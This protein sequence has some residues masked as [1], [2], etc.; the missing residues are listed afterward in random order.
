MELSFSSITLP[1]LPSIS[2]IIESIPTISSL[3]SPTT[4]LADS[5]ITTSISS[6]LSSTNVLPS[7]REYTSLPFL[8]A[9]IWFCSWLF[10]KIMNLIVLYIPSKILKLLSTDFE[11]TL[12]LSTILLSL[13]LILGV[14]FLIVRYKYLSGYSEDIKG[15][16]N[17]LKNVSSGGPKLKN[18]KSNI[19]LFDNQKKKFKKSTSNYLDEFLSAIKVFGYLEKSVFHE[20]TKNMTTQKLSH[21]EILYLDEKLG[22]SIVVEGVIQVY[23]RI[24]NE[25]SLPIDADD[26]DGDVNYEKGDMLILGNQRY[27][28]LNEV[29]SGSPLSS[30]ISTLDL[31]KPIYYEDELSSNLTNYNI[32]TDSFSTSKNMH[33]NPLDP[34][35]SPFD[36]IMNDSTTAADSSPRV[37]HIHNGSEYPEI[38]ARPKPIQHQHHHTKQGRHHHRRH[39]HEPQGA[40]IA[41]IPY[42][43]FQR[44]QSKYPKATSHMVTMV[45][46]RLYKV[47]MNTIHNYLGLTKEIIESEIRLNDIKSTPTANLPRYLYD[48]LLDKMYNKGNV[49]SSNNTSNDT[50]NDHELDIPE[51]ISEHL[52]HPAIPHKSHFS[53]G[54]SSRYVVLDSR[55]KSTHPGDLLS[56]VPLSR[57]SEYYQTHSGENPPPPTLTPSESRKNVRVASTSAVT[58]ASLTPDTSTIKGSTSSKLK[59]EGF[60]DDYSEETEEKSLR[61]AIIENMFK[62]LGISEQSTLLFSKINDLNSGQTSRSS[63]I[64]GLSNLMHHHNGSSQGSSYGGNVGNTPSS[65]YYDPLTGRFRFDTLSNYSSSPISGNST[66]IKVYNTLNQSQ[67]MKMNDSSATELSVNFNRKSVNGSNSSHGNETNLNTVKHE[68]S[69]VLHIKYYGPNTTIVEQGYFNSGLFYV[70]DGSLDILYSP[71]KTSDFSAH[72]SQSTTKK[73]YTVKPGGLA[74]YLT[75]I[76]GFRSLVSIRTSRNKGAIVAHISKSDYSKLMDQF[77][78]LQLPVATKLKTLLSKQ[79]LTIDYALEWCH[80]PAGNVLCSQGDLA[81]GFHIVLSGRFRALRNNKFE[82]RLSHNEDEEFDV[83]V[84]EDDDED[85]DN[86]DNLNDESNNTR[87]SNDDVEVLGEYGHAEAIG[88]VEVLTASRRTNS[89]IA[90]RD[91]ETARIPRTLFELLSLQDPSVM[92]KVS[93]VVANKALSK[94]NALYQLS[95][96]GRSGS[97]SSS[98]VPH[99]SNE[100]KTITI[101]PTV[102]GLPVREFADKLVHALKAIG[103]RV[104]SLDQASTLTHLGRHAFDERLAQLKLSGYFAYLEEE[105]ET[106]VYVCDT[107]LKSNWT[108]TCISQGDCILLLADADDDVVATGVGDYER[109]LMKLKTTA[110]TDLCLMHPEK[111]VEPGSTSIWLKNR[112]WVQGH[113]HIHMQVSKVSVKER[114][115]KRAN[116]I[117]DLAAKISSKTNPSIKLSFENV[118]TRAFSSFV[119]LN[120]AFYR[121]DNKVVQSHKNDFLRLARILSNEGVGLVLGGG[122]SRGISHVGVVTALERHGIPI[123]LI[124]GTSI[125]SFVGGLYAKEYNIVSIY[126]WSKKFSKRVASLWRSALDLTYPVTSYITGYEFNRG[127]WKVFG[128]TEIED[129]W[130]KYYCNSTNLTNSTMD[131]HETGYSWRFIRASMSLAGLLPP[132]AYNGCM[133]MDGGYLDNLPVSEMKKK[134]AKYIIAVDVGSV[135]DKSPMTY[136][137]TLSGF[138]VLFNRWNPFS[139][140]PNVPTMTD[141]QLRLA[142]VASVNAL[143]LAKKTPGVIYLRPPIED[144]ATLDFA[145]FDEIYHV[146]LDYADKLFT[147]LEKTGKLPPIAGMVSKDKTENGEQ[148]RTLYRR[149]SI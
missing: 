97:I 100:Y 101:L 117:S 119:K 6:S 70:I 122:G 113:H 33:S 118:K 107:P 13:T 12:N 109:L 148:S 135:D 68:F 40:T 15:E 64:V 93:R 60:S 39:T 87:V 17:K 29:K 89:I 102:V 132:I 145:K 28:L 80:I 144:Y 25:T 4:S 104:I 72:N 134:G 58:I 36:N 128:F 74:G 133:L 88:E 140:H 19:D 32:S 30:L 56:S 121:D 11:I 106:I 59:L 44:L 129:F 9:F 127:I 53:N 34:N 86:H 26:D 143:E 45:L 69:K 16:T 103:R 66:P 50:S 92:I 23:T 27:Q 75:S 105:Y 46:T 3:P 136:G 138:W 37:P 7:A 84:D 24:T 110:R 111:Y 126:G 62:L 147:N 57:K 41:I 79:I 116:I 67:L 73:L 82:P 51:S 20:L 31:F 76:V 98:T 96:G 139:K 55:L 38:V 114:G 43:A 149:N 124:G 125:G 71:K 94:V 63:S 47:T 120:T 112:L 52:S 95:P 18:S 81:N 91:S 65:R 22:F 115:T 35:V 5:I 131:I 54:S 1:S 48:G 142:Y 8:S 61:I 42:S 90:V 146:G 108:S 77:Y 85:S 99:I 130:I 21:D 123:D 14:G 49:T 141:I 78:F 137:D 83:E 2:L 10:F